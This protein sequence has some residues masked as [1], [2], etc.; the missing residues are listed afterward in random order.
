MR[1]G[2]LGSDLFSREGAGPGGEPLWRV[3]LEPY[4][5]LQHVVAAKARVKQ[6]APG[7]YPACYSCPAPPSV[8]VNDSLF[9]DRAATQWIVRGSRLF[10]TI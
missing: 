6:A 8:A 5:F 10:K 7:N 1:T 4:N 3:A 2:R 9:T